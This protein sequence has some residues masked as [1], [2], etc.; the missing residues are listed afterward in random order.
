MNKTANIVL[1]GFM[2]T[3][4]STVAQCLAEKLNRPLIDMDALI[5]TRTGY[6]IPRIFAER[7]ENFFRAIEKGVCYELSLHTN[8]IVSTGGGAL[9]N[10]ENREAMLQTGFVVCL[11]AQPDI[12]EQRLSQADNRPLAKQWREILA[13]RQAT[14][15]LLPHHISTDLL[16][17][18]Q[19]ADEIIT[20]WNASL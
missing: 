12:I 11:T 5:E 9:I 3:G 10:P 15:A 7:G 18:H 19:V 6:S 17:P 1:T 4:K 16:T 14:Y 2:G 8:T 13:Q 20:L